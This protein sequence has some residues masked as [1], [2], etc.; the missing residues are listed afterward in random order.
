MIVII[1]K[2]NMYKRLIFTIATVICV[3]FIFTRS[4]MPGNKSGEES[5]KVL[6]LLNSI[7]GFFGL[8]NL[9]T[10]NFV[11]KCAHFTEF[12]ILAVVAFNMFNA[13]RLK[14]KNIIIFSVIT[15]TSVAI[16]DELIQYFV[17]GRACQF[18]D[19]L[20][21]SSGGALGLIFCFVAFII[22]DKRNKRNC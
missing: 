17:P 10:H 21:D 19:V 1:D 14:L 13:Y 11:R 22:F 4:L 8:D 18:T 3:G 9:F 16:I 6:E 2:R 15:Y 7:A 20:I 12:A 5:S